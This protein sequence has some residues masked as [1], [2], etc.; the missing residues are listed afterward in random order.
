MSR[1]DH[2]LADRLQFQAAREQRMRGIAPDLFEA[3]KSLLRTLEDMT[4]HE[5]MRGAHQADADRVRE[6]IRRVEQ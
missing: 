1:K 5:F 2:E 6:L 4:P 3:A